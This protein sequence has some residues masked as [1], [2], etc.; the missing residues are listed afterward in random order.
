[1]EEME[2]QRFLHAEE[3]TVSTIG[4][5]PI[6]ENKVSF[7]TQDEEEYELLEEL[8]SI[9]ARECFRDDVEAA[10]REYRMECE[11][12]ALRALERN[13]H[14][15]HFPG[16]VT[17]LHCIVNLYLTELFLSFLG[18]PSSSL[19]SIHLHRGFDSIL[20]GAIV[21]GQILNSQPPVQGESSMSTTQAEK[22]YMDGIHHEQ[23]RA[24]EQEESRSP[25]FNPIARRWHGGSGRRGVFDSGGEQLQI[26][27]RLQVMPTR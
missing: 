24:Q 26:H 1:M 18:R 10:V 19:F 4:V 20:S 15:M 9:Q 25:L 12:L 27:S 7:S 17:P 5:P 22:L 8:K 6:N 2:M 21:D 13:V 23:E 3:S 14:S 11:E 16:S